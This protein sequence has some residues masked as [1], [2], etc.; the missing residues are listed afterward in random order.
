MRRSSENFDQA[1]D[2]RTD[3]VQVRKQREE[4]GDLQNKAQQANDGFFGIS[5][6]LSI[7]RTLS[8]FSNVKV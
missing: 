8:T 6:T 1:K 5:T 3:G 4:C 7:I 2:E